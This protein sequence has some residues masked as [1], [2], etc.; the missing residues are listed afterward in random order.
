MY[1]LYCRAHRQLM[2]TKSACV[3]VALPSTRPMCARQNAI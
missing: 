3:K 1:G 2:I